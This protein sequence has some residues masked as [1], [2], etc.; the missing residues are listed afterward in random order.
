MRQELPGVDFIDVSDGLFSLRGVKSAE[1]AEAR[2]ICA[3]IADAGY[4][5][6]CEA[7]RPGMYENEV[8][9]V[10]DRAMQRLG[11]EESFALITSGKFCLE[12]NS[13]PT[14]HNYAAS[15]RRIESGDVVA[16]EITPRYCGYWTQIV[17]TVC[18]GEKSEDADVL[19]QIVVGAV[20][21]AKTVLRA[22]AP[23]CDLVRKMREYVESAGYDFAMPCGHIAA[24]DLNEERLTED[25]NRPLEPGMLVIIHPTV[26]ISRGQTGIYWGESYLVTEDG[27]EPLMQSGSELRVCAG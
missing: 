16:L 27:F 12:S 23:I 5:A 25:N 24:I 21:E 15:N 13:L 18:V 8:V 6:A 14:L 9:A 4:N 3:G 26:A 7:I 22:G 11:S 2:R 19:R 1:E 17:R 20:D 10:V